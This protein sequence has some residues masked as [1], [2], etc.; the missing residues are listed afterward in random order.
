[1]RSG[2]KQQ[3]VLMRRRPVSDP[4]MTVHRDSAVVAGWLVGTAF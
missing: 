1:M 4:A 2:S 3:L